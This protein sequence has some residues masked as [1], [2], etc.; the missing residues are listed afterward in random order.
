MADAP[1]TQSNPAPEDLLARE[2]A[3]RMSAGLAS[4]AAAVFVT[5]AFLV[6][7][8]ITGKAPSI[9]ITAALQDAA[10]DGNPK[11]GL[12]SDWV[13]YQHDK[14][15]LISLQALLQIIGV[16]GFAIVLL[17]LL[18]AAKGRRPQVPNWLRVLLYVGI[19]ATII[20]TLMVTIGNAISFNDF[21]GSADHSSKA[22]RD[23]ISNPASNAGG[24]VIFIG[25]LT[26]IVAWVLVSLNAMR[27]GLL[28]RFLGFLGI[29][30]GVLTF[31][32]AQL[33]IIQ[34]FW[35]V[36]VG[37]LILGRIV[38]V[39]PA[40]QTGKA[41][42]WPT[43]QEAREARE[44]AGQ[45]DASPKTKPVKSPAPSPATSARKRKRRS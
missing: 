5:F 43:Q 42:P 44:R 39:P 45:G 41:E 21:V 6:Q 36:A 25:T 16:V 19:G 7:Q 4:L 24:A 14:L 3:G 26:V 15:A 10:G 34:I 2:E 22:A 29:L 23:A 12:L 37:L 30:G 31:F 38:G 40:W 20:G 32:L 13:T 1:D 35:L 8:I 27:V 18:S 9:T 11:T 28:T 33:P 17:Y